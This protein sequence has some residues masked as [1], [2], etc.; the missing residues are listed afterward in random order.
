MPLTSIGVLAPIYDR[1]IAPLER[2]SLAA[3]R[4]RTWERVVGTGR[5]LEIGAGTGAN[6]PYHP[7]GSRVIASDLSYQMLRQASDKVGGG[8]LPLVTCDVEALPFA[9]GSF[10]WAAETLAFCEVADPV[11]GLL[12]I[13]RVLRPGGRLVMLEHVRPSGWLGRLADATTAVSAPLWGEH[14]DRDAVASV[15]AAG[16]QIQETRHLWGDGVVLIVAH[17]P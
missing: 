13:R 12:E 14:F 5:G 4:R 9:D 16:F 17:A 11:Q 1:L 10:A 7:A 2:R 15:R 6:F 8:D 3:W